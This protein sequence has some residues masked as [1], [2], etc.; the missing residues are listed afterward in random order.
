[1]K[2]SRILRLAFAVLLLGVAASLLARWRSETV[3]QTRDYPEGALWICGRESCR[4]EFAVTL[5]DL[6]RHYEEHP[7]Q[8]V[9]CPR[10][11]AAESVRALRCPHCGRLAPRAQFNPTAPSCPHCGKTM[12]LRD[13]E[14]G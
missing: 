3:R 2:I 13:D 4:A 5:A 11:G 10:C 7:G 14:A 6:A 1:M 12:S 9:P 8:P